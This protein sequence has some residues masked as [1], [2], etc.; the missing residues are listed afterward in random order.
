M[1]NVTSC[2]VSVALD[3]Q[4]IGVLSIASTRQKRNEIF[5]TVFDPYYCRYKRYERIPTPNLYSRLASLSLLQEISFRLNQDFLIC[6][7]K[8]KVP[9][10]L[11]CQGII[12]KFC[13]F[14][15]DDRRLNPPSCSS[16]IGKKLSL[17]ATIEHTKLRNGFIHG[18]SKRQKA[19]ILKDDRIILP[20]FLCDTFPFLRTED[21]TATPVG[22]QRCMK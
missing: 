14:I 7:K 11:P 3:I 18:P 16:S 22:C 17:A 5:A 8:R 9:H 21:N 1:G 2:S 12:G 15:I 10:I 20:Q 19:V 13:I 4:G 6:G